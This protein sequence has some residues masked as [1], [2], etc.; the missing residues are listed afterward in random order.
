MWG[1]SIR[2]SLF[3][4]KAVKKVA[5][6]KK[7]SFEVQQANSQKKWKTSDIFACLLVV[8]WCLLCNS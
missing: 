4:F 1:L 3:F 6:V 2:F 8:G 5:F 7:K